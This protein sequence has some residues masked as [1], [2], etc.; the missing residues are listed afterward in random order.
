MKGIIYKLK[1]KGIRFVSERP[2]LSILIV[3]VIMFSLFE[4]LPFLII[5][6][7]GLENLSNEI[8]GALFL[9]IIVELFLTIRK[10]AAYPKTKEFVYGQIGSV[11]NNYTLDLFQFLN[12]DDKIEHKMLFNNDAL[13]EFYNTYCEANRDKIENRYLNLTDNQ[14]MVWFHKI[15]EQRV[16]LEYYFKNA[17]LINV[18]D[19]DL[20]NLL[21]LN[22]KLLNMELEL[23][24][25][26][27]TREKNK[28]FFSS[29]VCLLTNILKDIVN[30]G[31]YE[32]WCIEKHP[33]T[34]MERTQY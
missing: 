31:L 21:I 2:L 10:K 13:I 26:K 6:Q 20:R 4:N 5:F 24:K 12:I 28:K 7:E 17:L 33:L 11:L 9:L 1:T 29:Y 19:D 34:V 16:K 25:T 18:R 27:V 14:V 32:Y 30:T 22:D 3:C 15:E 8:L 23:K